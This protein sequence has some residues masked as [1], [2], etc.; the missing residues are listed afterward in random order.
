MFIHEIEMNFA[1][2]LAAARKHASLTQQALADR[3]GVHVTQIRRYEAG[4]STPTLEALRNIATAL[5][6]TTDSLLF[7]HNERG[8]EDTLALTFEATR[9]LDP[10]D[11]QVVK[12]LIEAMLLKHDA[13]RWT[14]A[15]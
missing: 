4:T 5:S 11:Q 3:A 14:N 9:H 1:T 15:S 12:E 2:H 13:K 6:V 10:H 8:P 7:D